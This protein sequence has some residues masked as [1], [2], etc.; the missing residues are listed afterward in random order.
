MSHR[1][2]FTVGETGGANVERAKLFSNPA[3]RELT[4]VFQFEHISI[5]EQNGC[6]WDLA[7]FSMK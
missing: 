6:K 1:D 2:C 7:P 5:D 4:C 3:R